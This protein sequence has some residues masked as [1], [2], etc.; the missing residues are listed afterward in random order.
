MLNATVAEKTRGKAADAEEEDEKGCHMATWRRRQGRKRTIPET[1]TIQ[2]SQICTLETNKQTIHLAIWDK[3]QSPTEV[4]LT[5]RTA[6]TLNWINAQ[7]EL[8]RHVPDV[9]PDY[10]VRSLLEPSNPHINRNRSR[11]SGFSRVQMPKGVS[12]QRPATWDMFQKPREWQ[13]QGEGRHKG[14]CSNS[15]DQHQHQNCKIVSE[16]AYSQA[17]P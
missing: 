14:A 5:L 9:E 7:L 2:T 3:A 6:S 17:G 11:A 8:P 10:I 13:D 4:K 1:K 15:H 12:T 16:K